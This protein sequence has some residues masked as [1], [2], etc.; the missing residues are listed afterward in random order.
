MAVS[1]LPD[2]Q[3]GA[4]RPIS[5]NMLM[6]VAPE[7]EEL[8]RRAATEVAGAA[9]VEGVEVEEDDDYEGGGAIYRFTFLI[10]KDEAKLP[11]G[12]LRLRLLGKLRDDLLARDD[13]HYPR[14]KLL[15]R[16]DWERTRGA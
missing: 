15:D 2:W 4:A 5:R 14:I 11:I 13:Q 12:M 3:G 9:G 7:I 8:A 6:R 10:N 16:A 1:E